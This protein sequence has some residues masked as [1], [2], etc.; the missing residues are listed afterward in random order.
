MIS[1]A[2]F[3]KLKKITKYFMIADELKRVRDLY[4]CSNAFD[5][6]NLK[7]FREISY[8]RYGCFVCKGS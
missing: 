6:T 4:T 2:K 8:G 3:S 7:K 5:M 1:K